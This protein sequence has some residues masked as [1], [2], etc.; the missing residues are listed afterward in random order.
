MKIWIWSFAFLMKMT[1]SPFLEDV[2]LLHWNVGYWVNRTRGFEWK[3]SECSKSKLWYRN[4]EF[5]PFL[6]ITDQFSLPCG[7]FQ[8]W[9]A[10]IRILRPIL[11]RTVTFVKAKLCI[12]GC[13][14]Q[15]NT[16]GS[17][18][19]QEACFMRTSRGFILCPYVWSKRH[20]LGYFTRRFQI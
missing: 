3:W 20:V 6:N 15:Q 4:P 14:G 18:L 11:T 2:V 13:F 16:V 10:E 19:R 9:Y 12:P 17:I 5:K 8:P 1:Y 7:N